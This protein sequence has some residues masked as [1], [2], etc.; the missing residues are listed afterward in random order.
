MVDFNLT[1]S[2]IT[3]NINVLNTSLENID[4]QIGLKENNK[5]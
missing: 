4:C 5:T 1:M 2:I 3:L